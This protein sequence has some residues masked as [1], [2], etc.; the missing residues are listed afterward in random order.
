MEMHIIQKHILRKLSESKML[1]YAQIKPPLTEGNQFSYHLKTLI[2][3]GYVVRKD[4]GYTLTTKGLHYAT[5][6]N[7]EHFSV[8]IQPKITTLIVCRNARGEYL[9]YTRNK[10]PFLKMDGFPYG[11]VHLGERVAQAAERELNEKTGLSA[12]L[13]QKGVM[14]LLITDGSGEV[15]AHTLFHIF[16]GTKPRG[17]IVSDSPLGKIRWLSEK[18]LLKQNVMP[19]VPETLRMAKSSSKSLRFEEYEFQ[20][21]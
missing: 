21:A 5:Q 1:R 16:L 15:I 10:Q 20:Q 19:G 6:V 14:Y 13:T 4:N 8:R 2:R 11:K 17:D 18:E 7:F 12:E 9:T 3:R